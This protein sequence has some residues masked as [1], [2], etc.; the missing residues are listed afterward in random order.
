MKILIAEDDMVSRRVLQATLQKWGHEVIIA[1]D[2]VE[3]LAAF[4]VKD[5]QSPP[6]AILDWMMPGL[7]GIE[8]CRKVRQLPNAAPTYIILLT[9]KGGKEDIV[10]GLDAGADDYLTK[11]FERT[12]LRARIVVG[13]RVVNLQKKLAERVK[14]LNFALTELKQA[15]TEIRNL[16]MLD[17][18]TGLYNRRGFLALSEQHRKT[19]RR[20]GKSFSLI[21]GDMDGLKQIND[22]YGHHKGSEAICRLAEIFKKSFRESD[23]IARIGGDEFTILVTDATTC[24][25]TIP[26]ARLQENLSNYNSQKRHPYQL[27]LSLG[28]VCA[29]PDHDSTIEELLIEADKVMYENKKQKKEKRQLQKV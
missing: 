11:P 14:E 19:A 25:I 2:G 17:E 27:S 1:Q 22:T 3:A 21:Y 20:A 23:I 28:S 5:G 15:E 29:N 8:V 9:A 6:L 18:L 12:E 16:S 4:Q 13:E 7:D 10:T 26:L 24:N